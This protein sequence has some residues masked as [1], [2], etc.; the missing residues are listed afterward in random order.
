MPLPTAAAEAP[1]LSNTVVGL[2]PRERNR[3]FRRPGSHD[4][5]RP[6]L[7]LEVDDNYLFWSNGGQGTARQRYRPT[8][9]LTS[10]ESRAGNA[11]RWEAKVSLKPMGHGGDGDDTAL[12]TLCMVGGILTL[13]GLCGYDGGYTDSWSTP[14]ALGLLAVFAKYRAILF[15]HVVARCCD[16]RNT[17]HPVGWDRC[18]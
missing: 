5:P 11:Y 18:Y 4:W 15:A 7:Q 12:T 8:P 17:A 10:I 16:G 6:R 1:T 13:A 2:Y 9:L 3:Q 14:V